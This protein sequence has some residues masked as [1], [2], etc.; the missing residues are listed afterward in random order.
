VFNNIKHPHSGLFLRE[1]AAFIMVAPES[2]QK[3]WSVDHAR[4]LPSFA[5]SLVVKIISNG[6]LGVTDSIWRAPVGL[7]MD[8]A[9]SAFQNRHGIVIPLMLKQK[10]DRVGVVP[11]MRAQRRKVQQQYDWLR[12]RNDAALVTAL[13]PAADVNQDAGADGAQQDNDD[14]SAPSDDDDDDDAHKTDTVVLQQRVVRRLLTT[15]A[16]DLYMRTVIDSKELCST[17]FANLHGLQEA[18][19]TYNCVERM[20]VDYDDDLQSHWKAGMKM[21]GDFFLA[22]KHGRNAKLND[23]ASGGIEE[24]NRRAASVHDMIVAYAKYNCPHRFPDVVCPHCS[25]MIG[26]RTVAG[27]HSCFTKIKAAIKARKTAGDHKID[28]KKR[29]QT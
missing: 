10:I 5:G 7:R 12:S 22:N 11:M 28:N 3:G 18:R 24:V 26:R 1:G 4:Q 19:L 23:E 17:T 27:E 21:W 6:L 20:F 2:G 25:L 16:Q 9:L 29:K 8:A 13:A 14:E 15:L